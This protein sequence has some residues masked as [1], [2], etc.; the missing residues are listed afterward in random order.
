MISF[1]GKQWPTLV[2]FDSVHSTAGMNGMQQKSTPTS[3]WCLSLSANV[4][5]NKHYK[6]GGAPLNGDTESKG[7]CPHRRSASLHS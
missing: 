1:T 4:T 6:Q 3:Q 5:S 7:W 2:G